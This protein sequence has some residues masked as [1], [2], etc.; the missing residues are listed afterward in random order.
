MVMGQTVVGLNLW[1]GQTLCQPSSKW[2]PV[3]NSESEGP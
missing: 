1:L 3:S 2:I